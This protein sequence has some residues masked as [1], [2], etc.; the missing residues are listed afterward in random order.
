[1]ECLIFMSE[2]VSLSY[3]SHA[4]G[5]VVAD[6]ALADILRVSQKNNVTHELTGALIYG[7]GRFIQVL[8]GPL[9]PL[10]ATMERIRSD[11]RHHSI[12]VVGPVSLDRREFPDWCMA[13]VLLEPDLE[14]AFQSIL[15]NWPMGR[16]ASQLLV[17]ALAL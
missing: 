10:L 14:P 5:G 4:T 17:K 8:E 2:L 15:D 6:A 3:A 13:R 12:D 1:M 11:P 7:N 9:E 16:A